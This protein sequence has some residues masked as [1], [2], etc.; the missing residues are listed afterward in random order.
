M[1]PTKSQGETTNLTGCPHLENAGP[2]GYCPQSSPI[3]M[4]LSKPAS[5]ESDTPVIPALW[6]RRQEKQESKVILSEAE[7]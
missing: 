7:A 5:V 2:R 6:R 4:R 1:D 3:K